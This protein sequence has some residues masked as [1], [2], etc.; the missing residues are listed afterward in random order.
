M[1][2]IN[3][4]EAILKVHSTNKPFTKDVDMRLIASRTP[5]F[6]GADLANLLNE[7]AILAALENK[8]EI[9]N[10]HIL[11]SIDKI[12][13]GPQ[14]KSHILNEHE[15][16][17]TAYH[18]AGHAIVA[19]LLPNT[20]PVSK[21]SII[22]RG[23][24]AGFT[25]KLPLEDKKLHTKTEFLEDMAVMLAGQTAEKIVFNEITT[26]AQGDLR[27]VTALAKQLITSYGMSEKM[28]LRTFGKKD[29]M[30][31]L[32]K[33]IHEQRDY[34]EKTA[35]QIDEEIHRLTEDARKLAEKIITENRTQ[36]DK[37]VVALKEKE[38]IEA[39]EFKALFEK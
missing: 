34:S 25:L 26:G 33:D 3:D 18:E 20:D 9:N 6:S 15:K 2:D 27:Q 37:I 39:E 8:K 32:G 31:F 1:P 29:D 7:S 30:V 17:V 28:G 23:S 38:T 35:E 5:G 16:E 21:V 13:I 14:R 12:M 10:D 11:E 22:A 36:L 19:H 24:A 4:R